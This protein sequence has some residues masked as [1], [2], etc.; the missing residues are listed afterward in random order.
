MQDINSVRKCKK[1][2]RFCILG[3]RAAESFTMFKDFMLAERE[4]VILL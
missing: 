1:T 4:V 2:Y 3:S